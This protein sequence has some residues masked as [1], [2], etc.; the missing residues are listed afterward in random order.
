MSILQNISNAILMY[1]VVD[2]QYS[3][4]NTHF[5]NI[6][7]YLKSILLVNLIYQL[8]TTMELG[9]QKLF[10]VSIYFISKIITI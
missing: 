4:G 8:Q 9:H 1:Y 6:L 7:E 2:L 3:I 5:L 10:L